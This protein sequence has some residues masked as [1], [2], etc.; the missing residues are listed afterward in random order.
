MNKKYDY[1]VIKVIKDMSKRFVLPV[2][3]SGMLIFSLG[4]ASAVTLNQQ[5][6]EDVAIVVGDDAQASD[7]AVAN[8]LRSFLSM[9]LGNQTGDFFEFRRASDRLNLGENLSQLQPSALDQDELPDLLARETFLAGD[10]EDY[11]YD[12]EITIGPG[13]NLRWFEDADFN[14]DDPMIGFKVERD[15]SILNFSLDFTDNP[16]SDLDGNRLVD[17]EDSEIVILGNEY[18]IITANNATSTIELLGGAVNDVLMIGESETYDINGTQYTVEATFIDDDEVRFTINGESTNSLNEGST[19]RLRDGTVIGVRE[20]DFQNFA[21]GIQQVEFTLG[22]NRIV[23]QDG[24]IVEINDEDVDDL[25]AHVDFRDVTGGDVELESITLEWVPEEEAFLA[26]GENLVMPGFGLSLAMSEFFTPAEEQF[27]IDFEG[28]DTLVVSVNVEDGQYSDL[29]LLSGN[30][31][32]FTIIGE[33]ADSR[34]V[35]S[36]TDTLTFDTDTDE[37]FVASWNDANDAESYILDVSRIARDGN[38]VEVTVRNLVSNQ[39]QTGRVGDDLDFGNVVLNIDAANSTE[40]TV[41]FS[42]N[43]GGTFNRLYTEEGLLM[44]LPTDVENATVPGSIDLDASPSTYA[45]QFVEED[46]DENIAAG[47]NFTITTRWSGGELGMAGTG[48]FANGLSGAGFIEIDDTDNFVGY[49]QSALA[50]RVEIDTGSDPDNAMLVYHGGES[51]GRVF[52]GGEGLM[53]QDGNETR[54]ISVIRDSQVGTVGNRD[55][56]IIGG[57][58]VNTETAELLNVN[59]PACGDDFEDATNVGS[60]EFMIQ[61]F[62]RGNNVA[63]V[64]AGYNAQDT[65]N[66]AE[67]I[68]DEELNVFSAGQKVIGNVGGITEGGN[69]TS[70]TNSPLTTNSSLL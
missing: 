1:N 8:D 30:T 28:D 5:F 67:L 61:T 49:V 47:E 45:L 55:L 37:W 11:E 60:G 3:M 16:V 18:N 42:I 6:N 20:I 56:I 39:D 21:G 44:Y 40:N 53:T 52:I 17:F 9:E 63:T 34:L 32:A 7:L 68:Q 50:T 57:T 43:S 65:R 4:A 46:E 33:D 58:C 36:S 25:I 51:Y 13:L 29:P 48:A 19:F 64:I 10:N 70:T 59:Y 62:D 23:L 14:E 31:S 38:N 66:A 35:T 69:S 22:A 15:Q 12:Q 27:E 24:E 26:P 54:E 2:L 41:T